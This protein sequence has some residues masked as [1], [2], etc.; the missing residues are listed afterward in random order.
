M[1]VADILFVSAVVIGLAFVPLLADDLPI[2]GIVPHHHWLSMAG[3][4]SVAYVF[5]HLLPELDAHNEV[6]EPGVLSSF[7]HH[8]YLVALFGFGLFYGLERLV[9]LART[10]EDDLVA[11]E[12]D[13]VFWIH[14][15][16][17]TGYNALIGYLLVD[18][19][20]VARTELLIFATVLGLHVFVLD[21]SLREDHAEIYHRFGRWL[22]AGAVLVGGAAGGFIDAGDTPLALLFSFFAGG[23]ALNAIKEEL[24]VEGKGRFWSFA[25]GAGLCTALL[26]T[27]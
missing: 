14:I 3:G 19:D 9:R 7:E 12:A 26:V 5:V 21:E 17:F 25:V 16:A 10:H 4:A 2:F 8:A 6:L 1:V 23:L 18:Y 20:F 15:G 24:P 27:L 13:L 11:S 22:F